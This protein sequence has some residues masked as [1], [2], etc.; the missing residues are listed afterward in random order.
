MP[1]C[2]E[3]RTQACRGL[4]CSSL[5]A[6][7]STLAVRG[8]CCCSSAFAVACCLWPVACGLKARVA[9]PPSA[10][11]KARLNRGP[12]AKGKVIETVEFSTC[13][14]YHN[15]SINFRD[16]TCLNFSIETGFTLQ[17]DYSNWKSG[18]QRVLRIW[19]QLHNKV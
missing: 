11:R 2:A 19:P 1:N 9:P 16:K 13:P 3:H 14:D 17:T 6:L 7:V 10:V 4:Q 15:I 8:I 5:T 12:Q 18:N